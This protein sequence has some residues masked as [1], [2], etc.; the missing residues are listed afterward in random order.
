MVAVRLG[1][2]AQDGSDDDLLKAT[3]AARQAL[4]VT[5]VAVLDGAGRTLASDVASN[6]PFAAQ[7]EIRAALQ[8]RAAVGLQDRAPGLAVQAA[9]PLRGDQGPLP[10]V[11]VVVQNLDDTWLNLASRVS[12]LDLRWSRTGGWW[13]LHAVSGGRS[14]LP[15]TNRSIRN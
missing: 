10:C 1:R 7:A 13:P 11:G 9:V 5:L 14:P 3:G 8:G 6:Q 2:D 4:R 12:G 15:W